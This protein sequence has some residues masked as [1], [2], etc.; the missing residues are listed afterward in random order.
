MLIFGSS[1]IKHFYPE[2]NLG[3][4]DIDCLSKTKV[5]GENTETH[6][7]EAMQYV[8][9]NNEDKNYVDPDFL[10]SI[11]FSH[12]PWL[13]KNGKWWKHLKDFHFLKDRGH[14]IDYTLV[15]ELR[16]EWSKRF[17]DK[18][19]IN[20]NKTPDT[21]FNSQV[22]RK[23][24]HDYLH[25]VFKLGNVPAYKL[26]SA[27]DGT[28]KVQKDKFDSLTEYQK[29]CTIFEEAQVIA[30]E[31]NISISSAVQKIITSL[32]KGWWND[33]CILNSKIILDGFKH[34]KELFMI[35]RRKL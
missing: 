24:N 2:Y 16:K 15:K 19:E 29:L 4:N 12:L 6:W 31:R 21:F 34:E 1:A 14:T 10:M 18:S 3:V 13:G 17:G 35:K 33:Y 7:C 28:T 22:K 23:Y 9:D 32:S 30:F 8:I 26:I 25:E 20:L 27:D 5:K 11:K